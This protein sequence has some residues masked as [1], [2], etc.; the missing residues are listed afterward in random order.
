MKL[1]DVAPSVQW[2]VVIGLARLAGL[3]TPSETHTLTWGDVN[4]EKGLLSVRCVKTE[5]YAHK[6]MR[7]V[8]VTPALMKVL[9]AAFDEAE[10]GQTN[11]VTLSRTKSYL[12][13][14]LMKVVKQ[15]GLTPWADAWQTLRRSCEIEWA[16]THPQFA[17]S[18]WIG[19]SITVSGKHYA[20]FIPDETLAKV[21]GITNAM[22]AAQNPA[23]SK[24]LQLE[25]VQ[26]P[27]QY[28]A[29]RGGIGGINEKSRTTPD[30][31]VSAIF[32]AFPLISSEGDGTRTR[33]HRID[34]PVL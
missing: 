32:R 20:N 6:A 34:S 19:H 17:V 18:K 5:R 11:V 16:Q 27:A 15:A 8:P 13:S 25:L 3:R 14:G 31:C 21:T 23:H 4:F 33:N 26:N 29:E 1:V 2:K 12:A 28:M 10:P 7:Q 9:E 30:Q 22:S 24:V